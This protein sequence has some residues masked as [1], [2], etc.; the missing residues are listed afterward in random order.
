LA[1][2]ADL[3]LTGTGADRILGHKDPGAVARVFEELA[4]QEAATEGDL[5]AAHS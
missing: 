1:G 5:K 4:T 2:A 3:S